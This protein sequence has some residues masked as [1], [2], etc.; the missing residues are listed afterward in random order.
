M[1]SSIVDKLMQVLSQISEASTPH[2]F[3]ELVVA[4]GLHKSTLHRILTL[5]L[6]K[7]LLQFDESSRTYLLGPKVFDL[8]K[9]AYRG[10]DI[11]S[12]ALNEMMRLHRLTGENVTIGVPVGSDTVYLRLLDSRH[13]MGSFPKPG[14]REPFHCSASGKALLAYRPN[15][16]ISV[17]LDNHHFEKYTDRT[18]TSAE[19]FRDALK[20]VRQVGYGI[21]DREE[22]DHL[23]GISA[24]VF[25]Y[26]SEPVAVLNIWSLHQRCPVGELEAWSDEIKKSAAQVTRLIG[27]SVPALSSLVS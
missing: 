24:P 21:N 6:Q 27:G 1:S 25:N 10:Y 5:G 26:L 8:V 13:S 3:S 15:N 9:N 22:Y 19:Q 23:V 12:I 20:L 18:I 14:L 2:T 16:M 4:S 11:Q 17:M 7:E